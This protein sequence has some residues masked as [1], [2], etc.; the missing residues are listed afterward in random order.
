[1]PVGILAEIRPNPFMN[2]IAKLFL[3]AAIG[4]PP[5]WAQRMYDSTGRQIG[6]VDAE[7]YYDATGRQIGRVDGT[8][9]AYIG[10]RCVQP[11]ISNRP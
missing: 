1:M 5:V 10:F 3:I 2:L 7:R 11:I 4:V 6:R 8:H 9:I